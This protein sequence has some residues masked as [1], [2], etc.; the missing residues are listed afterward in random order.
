MIFD[1]DDDD[2]D[3]RGRNAS[4]GD[5]GVGRAEQRRVQRASA[6][7]LGQQ[8]MVKPRQLLD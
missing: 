6:A 3:D 7:N 8:R 1:G 5:G 2:D 4:R